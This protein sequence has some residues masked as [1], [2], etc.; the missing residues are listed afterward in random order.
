MKSFMATAMAKSIAMTVLLAGTAS[1]TAGARESARAEVERQSG[2][3]RGGQQRVEAQSGQSNGGDGGGQRVQGGRQ[4]IES[5]GGHDD[6]GAARGGNMGFDGGG[7][8]G[9]IGG[10][11]GGNGGGYN[12]GFSGGINGVPESN[13]G[14]GRQQGYAN[15]VQDHRYSRQ[16]DINQNRAPDYGSHAP[17]YSSNRSSYNQNHSGNQGYNQYGDNH[18]GSNHGQNDRW[19][20]NRYGGREHH[21]QSGRHWGGHSNHNWSTGPYYFGYNWGHHYRAPS[22]YV[23]PHG[24]YQNSWSVGYRL[25]RSYYGSS[26]YVDYRPYGLARPPYGCRWVRVD[27]DLFLVAI[28]TGLIQDIVSDFYYDDNDGY[29]DDYDDH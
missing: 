13:P 7:Q 20:D 23:R 14:H 9:G 16:R 17:D 10:H 26:Y 19:F 18:Y 27:G 8:R 2:A 12:G 28:A 22:R 4:Q 24:Y 1:L 25:P 5:R 21:S 6:G 29:D 11:N 15:D 3:E